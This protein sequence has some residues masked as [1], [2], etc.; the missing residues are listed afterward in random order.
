VKG[1]IKPGKIVGTWYLR[2]E[3]ARTEKGARRRR[4]E[5]FRGTK[6][7]AQ[8]R[9]RDILREAETGGYAEGSRITFAQVA[10]RWLVS[11]KHRVGI[12]TYQ[13]YESIVRLH[14]APSLGSMRAETVRP[15]HVENVL[16]GW[17]AGRR[18]DREKGQLSQRTIAH[19]H[20][21]LRTIFR[22][23]VRMGILVRNPVDAV[24]APRVERRE[25]RALEPAGVTALLEA[26]AHEVD[27]Q[28]PIAVAIGTG[29]R[30]G[31][32]LGLRWSDINLE[33]RRLIVRRSVETIAG[34][35]R[36]KPPKTI[37]SARTIS[38]PPFVA[39]V[40]GSARAAQAQRRLDLGLGKDPDGWVFT[41]GDGSAW[42]PGAFSLHF[43]RLVKRAKLPHVRFHDLRHTFATS[44]ISSGVDLQTVSR[45]LGHE[46][47]AITS[48]VY[49]H[50]V[51]SLQDD[52]A[53]RID[54]MLGQAVGDG[55]KPLTNVTAK[56]PR[57]IAGPLRAHALPSA[58]KKARGYG[59][60]VV[61]PTGVEPVS[62]P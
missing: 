42:E 32:L 43:A 34:I 24:E 38:I 54:M 58:T 21:T 3:L 20:A 29:L 59:L 15:S 62:P 17:A 41:R 35:T 8:R 30:R 45:A 33:A 7:E 37:R 11:A 12:K 1:Q 26:A 53:A 9:L 36:T 61:A 2:V 6:A 44:A 50:A 4:R 27:L 49:L 57:M 52:A 13:R 55:F 60:S 25:M 23:A 51:Q 14:V 56:P 22:W 10:E 28:A 48:R 40:L 39:D 31:E 18:K 19:L 16:A 5:T 46:S 47:T